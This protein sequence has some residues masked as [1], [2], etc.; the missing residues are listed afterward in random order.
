MMQLRRVRE[1]CNIS[2]E[3]PGVMRSLKEYERLVSEDSEM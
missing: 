2:S 1:V 3:V